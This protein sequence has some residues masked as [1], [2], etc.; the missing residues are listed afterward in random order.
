MV[1]NTTGSAVAILEMTGT[2]PAAGIVST[3]P[4]GHAFVV[5]VVGGRVVVGASVVGGSVV[6]SAS[7]VV[8][9]VSSELADSGP[10]NDESVREVMNTAPAVTVATPASAAM[11]ARDRFV[12]RLVDIA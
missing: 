10:P 11:A 2:A 12:G 1:R 7:V 6:V 8:V 9:T 4:F 3:G 5:V